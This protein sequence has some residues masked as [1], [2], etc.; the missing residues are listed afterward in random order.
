MIAD[1]VG[2]MI[3]QCR[4]YAYM[5]NDDFHKVNMQFDVEHLQK[6]LELSGTTNYIV[7]QEITAPD[8]PS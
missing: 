4:L 6:I 3:K 1:A 7:F 8:Q 2:P 5:A